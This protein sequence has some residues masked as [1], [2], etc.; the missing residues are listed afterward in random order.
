MRT[1]VPKET[2]LN[3]TKNRKD[4][5]KSNYVFFFIGTRNIF[6]V[7]VSISKQNITLVRRYFI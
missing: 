5:E 1:G 3:G 2:N 6:D 4:V 7:C